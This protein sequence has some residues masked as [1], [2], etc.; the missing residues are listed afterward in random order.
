VDNALRD[1]E[2]AGDPLRLAQA[3]LRAGDDLRSKRIIRDAEWEGV[4]ARSVCVAWL[5]DHVPLTIAVESDLEL[6][7][8]LRHYAPFLQPLAQRLAGHCDP[9]IDRLLRAWAERVGAGMVLELIDLPP[10]ERWINGAKRW[11]AAILADATPGPQVTLELSRAL[12]PAPSGLRAEEQE[13]LELSLLYLLD[14]WGEE[15]PIRDRLAGWHA[16]S[17]LARESVGAARGEAPSQLQGR[18]VVWRPAWVPRTSPSRLRD[19]LTL[20]LR[21]DRSLAAI[22]DFHRSCALLYID[23]DGMKQHNDF[24][25]LPVGDQALVRITHALRAEVGD[26]AIRYAGDEWLVPWEG[27]D[28]VGVARK[29][30]ER[31][32]A[33]APPTVRIGVEERKDLDLSARLESIDPAIYGSTYGAFAG[34]V[35]VV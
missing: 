4:L 18:G 9:R 33:G 10:R 28:P 7:E 16:S 6:L 31:V 35:V 29:V 19:G 14:G 11:G 32:R 5:E 30:L 26:R 21:R 8:G 3:A 34:K 20:C 1:L 24:Y 22:E 25:G 15:A 12:W 13:L 2:R 17:A 23:V 27:A